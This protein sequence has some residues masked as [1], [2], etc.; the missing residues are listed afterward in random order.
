MS[1]PIAAAIGA[2]CDV[3]LPRGLM[4]ADIGGGCCDFASVSVGQL[5]SVSS[6]KTAGAAFTEAVTAHFRDYHSL[7][8]GY[9][10]AEHCKKEVGCVFPKESNDRTTVKGL[11]LKTGLPAEIS[12]SCEELRDALMPTVNEV[13]E[14]LKNAVDAVPSELLGDILEDGILLTGAG[15][16]MYG[17]VKRLHIDTELKLFLAPESEYA[18]IRG[19]AA[20]T[21]NM[22]RISKELF[23]VYHG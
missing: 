22:E 10:T 17:L 3:M 23:T 7:S 11:D 16:N 15:A 13:A 20:A 4:I 6:S 5:A 9:L 18:V 14:A 1:A 8:I 19:L 2:K 12:V 21:E